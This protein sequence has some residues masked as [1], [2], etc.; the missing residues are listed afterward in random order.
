MLLSFPRVLVAEDASEYVKK[1]IDHL[2][3]SSSYM[4]SEMLVKRDDWQR[5]S[6]LKGW[7]LGRDRSLVRFTAPK[8]DL[9]NAFLKIKDEMWSFSPKVN[10]II[11]IP[12]SMMDQSWMGSDFSYRDF[13]R[14]ED[15][16]E[17]YT[18]KLLDTE[19]IDGVK[20]YVIEAI[21][22]EAA[23]VV[24]GKEVLRI[25]EDY[26]VVEHSFYDQDYKLHKRLLAL[27]IGTLGGKLYATK[28]RMQKLEEQNRW[29]EV[30]YR[31]AKFGED[32]PKGF[33]TLSNLENPRFGSQ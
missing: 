24:W 18:H 20:V 12:P 7:T 21:P 15:I 1:A 26:I 29:T 27:E 14:A 16:L 4:V 11:K 32:P 28:L 31:E 2:R 22:K 3:D 8:K 6:V 25:R 33:F 30:H 10:R 5:K 9:G 19:T 13:A 17:Y 23:P